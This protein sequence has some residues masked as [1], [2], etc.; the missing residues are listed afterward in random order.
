MRNKEHGSISKLKH[1]QLGGVCGWDYQL[2][3]MIALCLWVS[4]LISQFPPSSVRQKSYLLK[5]LCSPYFQHILLKKRTHLNSS[6]QYK[7]LTY[8]VTLNNSKLT[9]LMLLL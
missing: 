4:L 7:S 2:H 8:S 9:F 1:K 5:R 3:H 6:L